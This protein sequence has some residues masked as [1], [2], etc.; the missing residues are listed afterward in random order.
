MTVAP[1]VLLPLRFRLALLFA[2][3]F[4]RHHRH[5]RLRPLGRRLRLALSPLDHG[6]EV[7]VFAIDPVELEKHHRQNESQDRAGRVVKHDRED[8]ARGPIEHARHHRPGQARRENVE[9]DVAGANQR[10]ETSNTLGVNRNQMMQTT[11]FMGAQTR[12]IAS[13]PKMTPDDPSM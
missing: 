13:R 6:E 12:H 9:R 1:P 4:G 2:T 10:I 8:R 5:P 11:S 7:P 3:K